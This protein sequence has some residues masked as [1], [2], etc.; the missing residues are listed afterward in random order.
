MFLAE[1][2]AAVRAFD[3]F[4]PDNDSH[5]EPDFGA[6]TIRDERVFWKFDYFDPTLDAG[7][8]DPADGTVTCRV[9]TVMLARE[10]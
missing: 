3:D 1:A 6:V 10:Y 9:L 2:I 4:T 5:G 8:E 7:S